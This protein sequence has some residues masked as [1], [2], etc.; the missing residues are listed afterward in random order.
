MHS[1]S[2]ELA[3]L[4]MPDPN[5]PVDHCEASSDEPLNSESKTRFHGPATAPTGCGLLG[6]TVV[7]VVGAT[8]VV[9]VGAT[10]VVV[11]G[12]IGCRV[13]G[14]TA[15]VVVGATV[16]AAPAVAP[17]A[18]V[19]AVDPTRTRVGVAD[20]PRVV[21]RDVD[22]TVM[23][24]CSIPKSSLR[25]ASEGATDVFSAILVIED[26]V[27]L[28]DADASTAI[29]AINMQVVTASVAILGMRCGVLVVNIFLSEPLSMST[30]SQTQITPRP[31]TTQRLP[32]YVF[33]ETNWEI[34]SDN[35]SELL[36]VTS[37]I[38]TTNARFIV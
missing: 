27:P 7:V 30:K 2:A 5:Q 21:S 9:V 16:V 6:A 20:P 34:E 23:R 31:L 25:L 35:S 29:I 19:G 26:P 3:P 33:T 14:A 13:V 36:R 8:V 22:L 17:P 4:V 28:G 24:R 38:L 12:A 11:V 18:L 37:L 1:V 32:N 10:V 15:A